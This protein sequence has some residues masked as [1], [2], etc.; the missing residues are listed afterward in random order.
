VT[1]STL[2]RGGQIRQRSEKR[3]RED[4]EFEP[5][6]KAAFERDGRCMAPLEWGRCWGP[7]TPHHIVPGARDKTL[8]LVLANVT[9]LCLGHHDYAHDHPLQASE[10]GLLKSAPQ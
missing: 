10:H 5:I 7:W 9:T 8:R 1:Y 4:R 3:I 2:K 6:R